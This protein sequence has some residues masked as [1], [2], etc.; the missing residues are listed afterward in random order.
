MCGRFTLTLEAADWQAAF[1][2]EME[3]AAW[4]PRFNIAPSQSIWV[5]TDA[6]GRRLEKMRWGLVPFWAK[7]PSVGSR[8]INARAETIMEK[9]SFRQAFAKRRCLILADGFFEWQ[10]SKEK[11]KSAPFYFQL[12]D[13][14]AFA[15][16]GLWESWFSPHG[17]E[18]RTCSIIT[19]QANAVVAPVHDRMPVILP[20]EMCWEW[21][22]LQQPQALHAL[23]RPLPAERMRSQPVSALVNS[24]AVD[25]AE[26]VKP[27]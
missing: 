13:G 11:G 2:L 15:F 23:L 19:T 6:A 21:L 25:R 7:D 27:L 4:Q 12:T 9:P 26:C 18:L 3:D 1:G 8:M 16:A 5:M 22:Q 17:E 10:K 14:D 20:R 24:P